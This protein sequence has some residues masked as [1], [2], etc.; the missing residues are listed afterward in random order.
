MFLFLYEMYRGVEKNQCS[1][2]QNNADC[3]Q[4]RDEP[5]LITDASWMLVGL[6]LRRDVH[7]CVC[8]CLLLVV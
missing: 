6:S 1:V 8:V 5:V 2:P 3:P 4:A 7:L